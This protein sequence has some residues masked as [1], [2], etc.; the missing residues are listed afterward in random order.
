MISEKSLIMCCFQFL[1][2][3]SC[4]PRQTD[5]ALGDPVRLR[6]LIIS[7]FGTTKVVGHQSYALTA[8]TPREMHGIHFQRLSRSQ[9]TW[10]FRKE[11]RKKSPVTP[12]GIGPETV[13]V[14][15]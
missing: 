13:R 3:L 15:A 10:F 12:P 9:G 6:P 8:F 11:Q 14:V 5:V 2:L 4:V 7:N 1:L